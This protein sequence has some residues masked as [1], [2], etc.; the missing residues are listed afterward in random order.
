[1]FRFLIKI[2]N[3]HEKRN[4]NDFLVR[5]YSNLGTRELN[6][7]ETREAK[8]LIINL[9]EN[10]SINLAESNRFNNYS[11]LFTFKSLKFLY[12]LNGIC[13]MLTIVYHFYYI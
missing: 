2:R 5:E 10:N 1:M 11:H 4:F 3:E 7:L 12:F 6:T 8:Q 9:A 13:L